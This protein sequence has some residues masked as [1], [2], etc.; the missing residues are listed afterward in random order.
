MKLKSYA[1]L[2]RSPKVGEKC[3]YE[4]GG[5]ETVTHAN[6]HAI[7]AEWAHWYPLNQPG[8]CPDCVFFQET[9]CPTCRAKERMFP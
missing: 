9:G 2:G 4:T 6:L 3:R 8:I 1:R 7:F 5:I